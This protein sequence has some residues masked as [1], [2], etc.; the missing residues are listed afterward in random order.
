MIK[1]MKNVLQEDGQA[2]RGND[3][4]GDYRGYATTDY[5]ESNEGK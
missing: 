5:L 3:D 2:L 1:M 4:D